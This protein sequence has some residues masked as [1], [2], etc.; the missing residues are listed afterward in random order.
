MKIYVSNLS[1]NTTDADLTKVFATYGAVS[2]AQVLM[3]KYTQ[4]SRGFGFVEMA[5]AS[6]AQRAIS[7]LNNSTVDGRPVSVAEARPR[8]ERSSRPAQNSNRW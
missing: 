5:D 6:E 3:D 8:E 1:F 2:S 4:R 7:G